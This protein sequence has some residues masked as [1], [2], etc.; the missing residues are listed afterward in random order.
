MKYDLAVY[1]IPVY[2]KQYLVPDHSIVKSEQYFT[3]LCH[4]LR[5]TGFCSI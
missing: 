1:T 3:I 4:T 5:N 2:A